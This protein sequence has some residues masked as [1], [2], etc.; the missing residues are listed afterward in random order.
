MMRE[1]VIVFRPRQRRL[2]SPASEDGAA[3]QQLQPV[4]LPSRPPPPARQQQQQSRRPCRS[5]CW[6]VDSRW[7]ASLA[8]SLQW[9]HLQLSWVLLPAALVVAQILQDGSSREA[10]KGLAHLWQPAP[11]RLG[12]GRQQEQAAGTGTG[13]PAAADEAAAE[14][15]RSSA[16]TP[17]HL[18]AAAGTAGLLHG[19]AA[20]A[21][22]LQQAQGCK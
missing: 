9:R 19:H 7:A 16:S 12:A 15:S 4:Q 8:A 2:S 3:V 11:A 6:Q 14:A 13:G 1:E 10:W 5:S 17:P 21:L 18:H 22:D 20:T